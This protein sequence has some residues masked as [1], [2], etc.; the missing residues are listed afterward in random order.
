MSKKK[1]NLNY[2]PASAKTAAQKKEESRQNGRANLSAAARSTLRKK[3]AWTLSVVSLSVVLVLTLSIIF[4]SY[5]PAYYTQRT[6]NEPTQSSDGTLIQNQ[7]FGLSE[8]IYDVNGSTVLQYPYAPE[9]WNISANNMD[10]SVAGVISRDSGEKE[11]VKAD[12]RSMGVNE[13]DFNGLLE[14]SDLSADSD[15]NVLL[16]YN[17]KDLDSKAY[18][19][20]FSVAANTYVEITVRV[21]TNVVSGEGAYILLKTSAGDTVD[22][23]LTFSGIND[24]NWTE[25]KFLIEGNKTSSKTLYLFVGLDAG[26]VDNQCSWAE[27][28]FVKATKTKKVS[29]IETV[30]ST[31]AQNTKT[32][33]YV[34]NVSDQNLINNDSSLVNGS[35]VQI[36]ETSEYEL[37]F[38]NKDNLCVHKLHNPEGGNK[39]EYMVLNRRIDIQQS[40][41]SSYYRLSFWAK[42]KGLKA[43]TGAFFYAK[44]YEDGNPS[45][46]E[47]ISLVSTSEKADDLNSGW[48]EFS[49]LFKPDNNKSYQVEIVFS[50]GELR[51]SNGVYEPAITTVDTTGSLYVTEFEL[52]EIYQSEFDNAAKG[53]NLA[54]VS[55][56]SNTSSGLITNGSFDSPVSNASFDGTG[57]PTGFDPNGWDV[58]FPRASTSN[59]FVYT[60]HSNNDVSFGIL[61][62]DADDSEK[63]KYLGTRNYSEYFNHTGDDN[64][65]AVNVKNDT[66]IG[67]VSNKFTLSP[68]SQY[69]ISFL[70]KADN[71]TKVNAYL[72]GDVDETFA[73]NDISDG[74]YY[75]Y[76]E[77]AIEDGYVKYNFI[78]KTGDVSKSVALELWVGQKNASYSTSTSTWSG[79]AAAG[80]IVAFDEVYAE[81]ITE[82]QFDEIVTSKNDDQSKVFNKTEIKDDA[83]DEDKITDVSYQTSKKNIKVKDFSYKDDTGAIATDEPTDVPPAEEVVYAPIDWLLFSSLILSVAV[84][85]FL[86]AM[87]VK[88]FNKAQKVEYVAED[89]DYKN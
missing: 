84:I 48:E 1:N 25:Y 64:I 27:F 4:A 77:F 28:D 55:L 56:P 11:K 37:P 78:I 2:I 57:V 8:L 82:D 80:T 81:S 58:I 24:N 75:K 69:V 14:A 85:I 31:L 73:I 86:F 38:Y 23:D 42:T 21:R 33:S 36:G 34:E 65:L 89:P 39:S 10:K 60:P 67:F 87:V 20:S 44:V 61:S 52:K 46:Y 19:N 16:L 51:Y 71:N 63:A 6:N 79:T 74:Q 59:G 3:R 62:K 50:L 41:V 35:S 17:K 40:S 7:E 15:A 70:V 72:T 30:E 22:A 18:S 47:T 13:S 66:A 29:Y 12:L 5:V 43:E 53:P 68:N 26:S 83:E 88:K 9:N 32:K 45:I 54:K 49:F 76:S